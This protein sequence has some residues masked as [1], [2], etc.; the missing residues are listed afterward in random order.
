MFASLN[1]LHVHQIVIKM[2][3]IMILIDVDPLRK[4]HMIIIRL[5][6]HIIHHLLTAPQM[7]TPKKEE[8][9]IGLQRMI[10]LD[11]VFAS[12]APQN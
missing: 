8:G 2:H 5:L 3:N 7:W 11:E 1:Y 12:R 9:N 4:S 6:S 10:Y